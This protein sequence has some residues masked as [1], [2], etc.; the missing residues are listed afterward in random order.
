M[1]T[2]CVAASN[3]NDDHCRL[4]ALSTGAGRVETSI[5][6]VLTGQQKVTKS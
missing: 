1:H 3:Q 4:K 2:V 5:T 6:A